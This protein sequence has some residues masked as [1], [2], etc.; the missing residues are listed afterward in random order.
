MFKH[1]TFFNGL[2]SLDKFEILRRCYK[3]HHKM[4]ALRGSDNHRIHLESLPGIYLF[5]THSK[6]LLENLLAQE[7]GRGEFDFLKSIWLFSFAQVLALVK[8]HLSCLYLSPIPSTCKIYLS[9]TF[10]S[11]S[12]SQLSFLTFVY[13]GSFPGSII[14]VMISEV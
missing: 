14:T 1:R 8:F 6:R 4:A 3:C 2:E 9:H 10:I 13:T 7:Q 5:T 11:F 12:L